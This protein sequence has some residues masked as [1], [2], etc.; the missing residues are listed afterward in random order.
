VIF[1][2][3]EQARRVL[4]SLPES[5]G[6]AGLFGLTQFLEQQTGVLTVSS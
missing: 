1:K 5:S 6:R 4:K 3:L 2:Y